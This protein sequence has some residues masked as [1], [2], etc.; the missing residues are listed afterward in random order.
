M[1]LLDQ[2]FGIHAQSLQFRETRAE[3]IANNLSN[4]DTPGY[5]ARDI[6]FNQVLEQTSTQT[7]AKPDSLIGQLPSLDTLTQTGQESLSIEKNAVVNSA[8][9]TIQYR[10]P[11]Q[12]ALDGNTVD[13]HVEQGEFTKN[14]VR[15]Q[16]S[17]QFLNGR[18]NGLINA[19]RGE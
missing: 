11:L 4:V 5:K 3:M 2:Y 7:T 18:I 16:T 17:M 6:D 19:L 12:P 9:Y 8:A 10:T 15:Y 14:A 1:Q 13:A